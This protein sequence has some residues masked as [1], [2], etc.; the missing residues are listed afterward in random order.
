V[1]RDAVH[2]NPIRVERQVIGLTIR[3][4]EELLPVSMTTATDRPPQWSKE[5]AISKLDG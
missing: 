2:L 4:R 1:G 5:I 3:Y